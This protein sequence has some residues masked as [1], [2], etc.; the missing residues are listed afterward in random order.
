MIP[1]VL[2][3]VIHVIQ[4]HVTVDHLLRVILDALPAALRM[5]QV[6]LQT[7]IHVAQDRVT[8]AHVVHVVPMAVA[9]VIPTVNKSPVI[10]KS[11]TLCLK[12]LFFNILS[13]RLRDMRLI[14]SDT[15]PSFLYKPS[16]LINLKLPSK[17]GSNLYSIV[18]FWLYIMFNFG[19]WFS[20]LQ[21]LL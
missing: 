19:F 16:F 4:V 21:L 15:K 3:T 14:I 9:H 12:L 13:M 1:D 5:A 17:K 7:M 2:P 20:S 6:M 8:V 10:K 18:L 11:E